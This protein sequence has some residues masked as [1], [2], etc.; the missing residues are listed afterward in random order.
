MKT[1][2]VIIA[3]V[4]SALAMLLVVPSGVE[5]GGHGIGVH[6]LV[7]HP[8]FGSFRH[9]RAF[10]NHRAFGL[11]PWPLYGYD[12]VPSYTV[13]DGY[14]TPQIVVVR[15]PEPS[16]RPACHHSEQTYTVPSKNGGT[17]QVKIM[18]C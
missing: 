12:Y 10:G 11:G 15:Q 1:T 3:V 17:R 18:R 4:M 5:A 7:G 16:P 8:P 6:S 14:S 13:D 9:H 2:H